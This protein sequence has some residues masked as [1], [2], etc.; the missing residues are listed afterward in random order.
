MVRRWRRLVFTAV[1]VGALAVVCGLGADSHAASKAQERAAAARSK[2]QD[3]VEAQ[4]T[5]DA[6]LKQ[7]EA[8]KA[9]QAVV[10]LSTTIARGH[11]PPALMAKALLYRGIAYRKQDKPAQA[12]A[13]FTSALWLKGGLDPNNRKDAQRQRAAAYREA[14][15]SETGQPVA[16]A[17]APSPQ[18]RHETQTGSVAAGWGAETTRQRA[19]ATA[20]TQESSGG[21]NLFESLFGGSSS[22][23][24]KAHPPPPPSRTPVAAPVARAEP[25]PARGEVHPQHTATSAWASNTQV[26]AHTPPAVT[27]TLAPKAKGKYR[28]QIGIVRTQ[29]Q[30]DALAA[31]VRQEQ[32]HLLA[33]RRMEIDRAVV[34]NMGSFYRVRLGPFASR[35]ETSAACARLKGTGLDCLVVTQ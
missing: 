23:P 31:K 16:V 10:A 12:I 34:G 17:H 20:T 14:G 29:D 7:L 9:N 11:L 2:K 6:A 27:G 18:V 22:P 19:P 15:L 32:G 3:P 30:A 4:R 26:R 24:P 8:G 21:W 1:A 25:A 13:D 28:I 33:S 35:K 5:I